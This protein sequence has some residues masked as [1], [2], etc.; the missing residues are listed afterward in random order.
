MW[1]FA[2]CVAAIPHATN[3]VAFAWKIPRVSVNILQVRVVMNAPFWAKHRHYIAAHINIASV[4]YQA[5][6]A[7]D[8]ARAFWRKNINA[9]MHARFPP[10]GAYQ[11]LRAFQ[12]FSVAPCTGTAPRAGNSSPSA[13]MQANTIN[14]RFFMFTLRRN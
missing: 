4:N 3:N 13:S 10:H 7:A 11:K 9:F 5:I 8:N 12:S 1:R 2:F 6:T 14:M